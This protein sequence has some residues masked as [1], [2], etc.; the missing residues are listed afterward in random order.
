MIR[1]NMTT[2]EIYRAISSIDEMTQDEFG[3][4]YCGKSSSYIRTMKSRGSDLPSDVLVSIANKLIEKKATL[5]RVA[6]HKT[7]IVEGLIQNL[8]TM[9]VDRQ[10]RLQH[11]YLRELM[12]RIVDNINTEKEYES[13]LKEYGIAP[14][15]IL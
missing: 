15:A 8:A 13:F 2:E 10:T 3:I 7:N 4:E 9:V 11:R 1:K 5:L 14:M 12:V 6:P